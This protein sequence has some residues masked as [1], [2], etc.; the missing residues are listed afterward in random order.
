MWMFTQG[1]TKF[2]SF[3]PQG[4]T[5]AAIGDS[6]TSG[7]GVSTA[8]ERYSNLTAAA[9]SMTLTN[10]GESGQTLT[11]NEFRTGLKTKLGAAY[12]KQLITILAGTNDWSFNIPIGSSLQSND[13][14][15][16][17]CAN[18]FIDSI[19]DNSFESV[20]IFLL[21]PYRS[22]DGKGNIL[23]IE[24]VNELGLTVENYNKAIREVCIKRQVRYLNLYDVSGLEKENVMTW[25]DDGLHPNVE[26][27]ISINDILLNYFL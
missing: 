3:N 9:K 26:G 16:K 12:G 6:I 4:W 14:T 7:V 18:L 2:S 17:A 11:T 10:L 20:I 24:P 23:G 15:I 1:E 19:R 5:W 22:R 25:T 27:N 13:E 8:D 21:T